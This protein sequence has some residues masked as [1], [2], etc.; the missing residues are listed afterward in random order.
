MLATIKQLEQDSK[1]VSPVTDVDEDDAALRAKA[2]ALAARL[3]A[4]S[5]EASKGVEFLLLSSVLQHYCAGEDE[6][7]DLGVLEV[8]NGTI[9]SCSLSDLCPSLA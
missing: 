2:Q 9:I 7:V 1:H 3:N 8:G 4:L 5:G 6:E